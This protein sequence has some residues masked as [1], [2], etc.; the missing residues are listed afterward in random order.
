MIRVGINGYGT[1]GKR[2]ADA[3]SLQDDMKVTGVTKTRPDFEAK[4]ALKKG[5]KLFSAI[6]GNEEKFRDRGIEIEGNIENLID[7]VDIIIDCSP[8]GYG[9]ENRKIYEKHGVKAIFQGGE[10]ANI[11]EASF[12]SMCNYEEAVGKDYV[13]VVSCNTTGMGRI[14]SIIDS[15]WGIEKMR[16]VVI[17]RAVDPK[18]DKK[19]PINA[20][21]PNPVKLPSHHGEDLKT[22]MPHL[23]VVTSA[24]KVPTTLMHVHMINA[25]L[26]NVLGRSELIDIMKKEPRIELF[27]SSE[28]FKSTA[29]IIE[30]AREVRQ[31][32]DLWENCVWEDSVAVED[33][34]I[35]LFQA[36][37]QEAIVVPENVDAV[38]AMMG[39][40]DREE[41]VT[42]TN[43]SL[44]LIL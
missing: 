42:K 2:V 39:F 37:H 16:V 31:R 5:Y 32:N 25:E 20:I 19:G 44:G 22:V 35:Y 41:S 6:P 34:E 4:M 27:N 36:I 3:I 7:D 30:Y 14:A 43:R 1:I 28:G 11:A 29:T 8:G 40:E 33:G 13:R 26:K 18:D 17:R 24:V 23:N 21:A 9:A 12:I 10:K 15:E 38:R